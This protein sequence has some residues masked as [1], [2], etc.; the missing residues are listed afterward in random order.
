MKVGFW[1][2]ATLLINFNDKSLNYQVVLYNWQMKKL[3]YSI[4]FLIL[5]LT[6]LF[7]TQQAKET[8][9]KKTSQ[10]KKQTPS[11]QQSSTGTYLVIKVVDGDTIE[12]EGGY[13]LR[14]IGIDT[15][16]TVDPRRSVGCFGKEASAKNKELVLGQKVRL[17]KD[18]SETD[19][20]GRLLR[21]V[22]IGDIFVNKYLVE[23]GF[24]KASSYPPDIKYQDIF[25]AAEKTARE[26]N[27]GL[28]SAC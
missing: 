25:R 19:K 3:I 14:Y 27:K 17:E 15:L 18:V 2:V 28:W 6:P 22:Y 4:A 1:S 12:I 21:Y 5:T 9:S 11:L 8:S 24:A 7:V 13:K 26:S 16:E 10:T 23:E 20:Y